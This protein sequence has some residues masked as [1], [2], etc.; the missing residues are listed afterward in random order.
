MHYQYRWETADRIKFRQG[1]DRRPARGYKTSALANS[2]RAN[3]NNAGAKRLTE[4]ATAIYLEH[5]LDSEY[6]G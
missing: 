2:F 1:I 5:Y 4:M 6:A 3:E